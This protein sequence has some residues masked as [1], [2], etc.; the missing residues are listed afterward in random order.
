MI[1]KTRTILFCLLIILFL[2]VA[3]GTIFYSW[4][5]RF[6]F[7]TKRITQT[8]A[9][10]FKVLPKSAR[11]Y[12][13][14]KSVKKTD[15]FFGAAYLDNLLPKKYEVEIKKEGYHPW[16]KTLEIKERQVTDAKNIV[17]APENPELTILTKKAEEIFVSPDEK[18]VILREAGEEGWSLKLLEL[19]KNVKSHLINQRNISKTQF[20][21]S[22]LRF[23]PDS[24]RILLKVESKGEMQ[25]FLL[26][27][28]KNPSSL[29]SL[30]F[31]EVDELRSSPPFAD[32]RVKYAQDAFFH[33]ENSQKLFL[34]KKGGIFEGDLIQKKVSLPLLENV[35]SY[36]ISKGAFYYLAGPGPDS[37]FLFK[38]D[39]SF[40]NREKINKTPFPLEKGFDY[41][42]S[43][44]PDKIF[45]QDDQN[46]FLFNPDLKTFERFFETAKELK[47]SPDFKKLVYFS[48]YEI[49]ILFLK[50]D[51]GQPRKSAG[52][53][54]FIARF[55][56]KIG[57]V[58]W[59][60]SH[61]LIFNYPS[62][63]KGGEEQTFFDYPSAA[64]G[65]EEQ[66]F[67]DS[68]PKIKIVEIDDRDKI[69][70]VDLAPPTTTGEGLEIFF[71]QNDKKLYIFNQGNLYSSERLLP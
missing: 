21:L 30:D 40:L 59:Y 63:A 20:S 17:L 49:W 34:Y 23:S 50:E 45:L 58:F 51:F 66:T 54:V 7:E 62:A 61:Y 2:I 27:L 5:Y 4:G 28:D 52:E 10:Y 26:D 69:N 56:E 15:F 31:L 3:P 33:P 46:L 44:S 38:T 37:G 36:Q 70:I 35:I 11:I 48:D 64:K 6:N 32:A 24:K 16:K 19:E 12:L 65:G 14:G 60:S 39:F 22:D 25:Y 42:I 1:K 9:F 67:F 8:G 18:K 55:S 29:I 57:K 53:K 47:I 43:I 68:G 13:N 71:N 41:K